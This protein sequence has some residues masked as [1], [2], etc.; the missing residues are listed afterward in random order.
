MT[1]NLFPEFKRV[2]Y[3]RPAPEFLFES[4]GDLYNAIS[5]LDVN[6]STHFIVM[7]GLSWFK[8]RAGEGLF[9]SPSGIVPVENARDKQ[10]GL[11]GHWYNYD[12]YTDA[13]TGEFILAGDDYSD[14]FG[15]RI[16]AKV[17]QPKRSWWGRFIDAIIG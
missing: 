10:R 1:V 14:L 12:I 13:V 3:D 4:W 5:E 2:A 6:A 8:T 17:E 7:D 11:A 9:P 15:V 16:Y